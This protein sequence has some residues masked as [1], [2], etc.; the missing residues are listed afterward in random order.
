VPAP[1]TAAAGLSFNLTN[2][3]LASGGCLKGSVSV[4]GTAE[5]W[6]EP[7]GGDQVIARS[8]FSGSD[9]KGFKVT[10]QGKSEPQASPAR[11]AVFEINTTADWRGPLDRNFKSEGT[12]RL[13]TGA[14]GK[15]Q[16]AVMVKLRTICT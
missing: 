5:F 12:E 7:T 15:P 16:K 6:L 2:W 9:G 14:D 11:N 10:S 1:P 13:M 3:G 8:R 4:T